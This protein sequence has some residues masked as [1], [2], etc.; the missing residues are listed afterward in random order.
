MMPGT[1][2][3]RAAAWTGATWLVACAVT[4]MLVMGLASGVV[5]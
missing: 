4:A 3:W 5:R 2:Y 1:P